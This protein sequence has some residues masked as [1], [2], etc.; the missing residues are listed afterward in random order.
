M[1]EEVKVRVVNKYPPN[2]ELIKVTIDPP[3]HTVFCYGP[4]IYNP[5]GRELTADLIFHESVHAKQQRNDP[6]A[7]WAKYISDLDFRYEQELEAYGLQYDF[8]KKS[9]DKAQEEATA[10]GKRLSFSKTRMLSDMLDVMA[11]ALAGEAYGFT[12]TKHQAHTRIRLYEARE[13]QEEA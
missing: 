13:R 6:D 11:D 1:S 7:W 2:Y 3:E 5:S 12:L 8:A 4:I 9:F 10:E